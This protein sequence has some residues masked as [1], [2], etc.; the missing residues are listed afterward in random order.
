[1]FRNLSFAGEVMIH[2]FGLNKSE[3]QWVLD[4]VERERKMEEGEELVRRQQELLKNNRVI[5]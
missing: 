3:Y 1:M 4:S 5:V 2:F